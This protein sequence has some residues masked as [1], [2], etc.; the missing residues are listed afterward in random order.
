MADSPNDSAGVGADDLDI[1]HF[2]DRRAK[3]IPQPE[4]ASPINDRRP[5]KLK[6]RE[7]ASRLADKYIGKDGGNPQ[8]EAAPPNSLAVINPRA[9]REWVARI[10]A[11]WQRGVEAIVGTGRL[12]NEA[13]AALDH[14]EWLPMIQ[15]ELPFG[16][17]VAQKLMKIA[18]DG[19]ITNT[20]TWR[21]LPPAWTTLYELTKLDDQT[22][23]AMRA[24]GSINPSMTK[25][26]A[27]NAVWIEKHRKGVRLKKLR[28]ASPPKP[29]NPTP[30][31]TLA[32]PR[33]LPP[34]AAN[35][36]LENAARLAADLE[37]WPANI[38]AAVRLMPIDDRRKLG[39]L[40]DKIVNWWLRVHDAATPRK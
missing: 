9:V 5:A 8:L 39:E 3:A 26:V 27:D 31:A 36:L 22:F 28:R 30:H 19:R 14:G 10:T 18:A 4:A 40:A 24:E 17:S 11:S 13:K 34:T 37:A 20:A 6:A 12:L 38:V 2:L 32:R 15:R 7:A 1:P 23:E 25:L 29:A 35:D 16:P 21:Y 33:P